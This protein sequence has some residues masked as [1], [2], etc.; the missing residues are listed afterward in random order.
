MGKRRGTQQL[1]L[2]ARRILNIWPARFSTAKSA[3]YKK[4]FNAKARRNKD[5]AWFG[6]ETTEGMK[7]TSQGEMLKSLSRE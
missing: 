7:F 2:V 5:A 6:Y 3:K 1:F 4:S